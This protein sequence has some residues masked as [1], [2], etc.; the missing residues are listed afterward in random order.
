[1]NELEISLERIILNSTV[2]IFKF[3]IEVYVTVSNST[4]LNL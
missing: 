3:I 1:M 2:L 4:S